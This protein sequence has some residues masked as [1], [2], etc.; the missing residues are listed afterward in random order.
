MGASEQKVP[1]LTS[2]LMVEERERKIA[3]VGLKTAEVQADE[4]RKKLH[5]VEI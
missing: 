4:Q 5:Y 2:K 3:Q 1:E